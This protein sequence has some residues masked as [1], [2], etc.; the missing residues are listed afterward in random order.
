LRSA[1]RVGLDDVI[2]ED[3]YLLDHLPLNAYVPSDYSLFGMEHIEGGENLS[4]IIGHDI[5][6]VKDVEKSWPV[7]LKQIP[8]NEVRCLSILASLLFPDR[9]PWFLL[10]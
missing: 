3:L 6:R 10:D 4:F 7:E 8:E 9:V 1:G 2:D 5:W